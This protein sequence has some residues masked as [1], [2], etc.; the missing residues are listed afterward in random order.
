MQKVFLAISKEGKESLV[1]DVN[2][3]FNKMTHIFLRNGLSTEDCYQLGKQ[4]NAGHVYSTATEWLTEAMKRYDEY[5]DQHQVKALDIL[6]ELALSF[7]GNN[8]IQEAKKIVDKVSRM[9][10]ESHIV[11]YFKAHERPQKVKAEKFLSKGNNQN[12]KENLCHLSFHFVDKNT[13]SCPA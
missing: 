6:E 1:S 13:F 9:D 12:D 7:I 5:Y 11:K 4:L 3:F 2:V 10:A 8:Q